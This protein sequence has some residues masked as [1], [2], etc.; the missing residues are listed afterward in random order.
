M[1]TASNAAANMLGNAASPANGSLQGVPR[2]MDMA[3]TEPLFTC[4]LEL[5]WNH[6]QA[7]KAC[8]IRKCNRSH[9]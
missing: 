8:E 5:S 3:S 2:E 6:S 7:S 4:N 1:P 9:F